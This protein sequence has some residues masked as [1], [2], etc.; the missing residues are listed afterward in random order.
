[1]QKILNEI[2]KFSNFSSR[3]RE[4]QT[5]NEHQIKNGKSLRKG[6][7]MM[8]AKFGISF[9]KPSLNQAG[10]LVNVYMDGS[11]RLNHGG[12]EMGQGLFIKVAQVV[13]ECFGVL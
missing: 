8:P 12:T 6:I 4:I 9:N 13:A 11:I 10:A 2:E 7:A 3:F 1:M 5:F